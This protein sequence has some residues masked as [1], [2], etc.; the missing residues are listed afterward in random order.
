METSVLN[1]RSPDITADHKAFEIL[2]RE[3]YTRLHA[4]AYTLARDESTA[5]D[6]V[7]D[8]FITAYKKMS[9]FDTSRDFGS[10]IRG[11]LRYKYLQHVEKNREICME[12]ASLD[13]LEAR[14]ASLDEAEQL[15]HHNIFNI[16][17]QHI[18]GLDCDSRKILE[19]F[20]YQKKKT[21]EIGQIL[22]LSAAAVRKRMER[23]R[24]S[25]FRSMEC[26]AKTG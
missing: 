5:D 2:V 15:D 26:P 14:Y 20:Y 12:S 13:F 4:Y 19:L 25:I 9:S 17:A 24:L 7:Q 18:Q 10:W 8:S 11:I 1:A 23:I 21:H 22:G 16:M 3:H 6:L